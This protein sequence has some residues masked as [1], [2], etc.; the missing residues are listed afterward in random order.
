MNDFFARQD[1]ARRKSGYLVFHFAGALL[2]IVVLM[3]LIILVIFGSETKRL[4]VPELFLGVTAVTSAILGFGS[5]YKTL[6][7]R[8]GGASVASMMGGELIQTNTTDPLLRRVLNLVEEMAI[9]SGVPMPPVFL[10]PHEKGINAFAAGY[11]P[12]DAV[13]GV[14]RGAV[15]TLTRDELQG[16]I[17]H[18][19]SHILNGDMRLNIRLI[20]WVHGILLIHI[21]GYWVFRG[22]LEVSQSRDGAKIGIPL[23]A[24]GVAFMALGLI[25]VLFGRMI[26]SAV[27]RQREYLADAS[28]VQFT[29]NPDGIGNALVKIGRLSDHSRIKHR[30]AE[31]IS[32]MFFGSPFKRMS[33]LMS[34]HPPLVNRIQRILPHFDGNFPQITAQEI[35]DVRQSALVGGGP[36]PSMLSHTSGPPSVTVDG[37]EV[38]AEPSEMLEVVGAPFREHLEASRRLISRLPDELLQAARE[39]FGS[40]A[41]VYVLLLDDNPDIRERQLDVLRKQADQPVYDETL[42]LLKWEH[43]LTAE[44]RL[45]LVDLSLGALRIV[46]GSVRGFS[47]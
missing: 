26:K 19:F 32:H 23:M 6:A 11:N 7:L 17:A 45:P 42:R 37:K 27:S 4:F 12:D 38:V 31:E 8:Q 21:V 43:E 34:T 2:A 35:S 47:R 16:V 20:G 13:V 15:E 18:E 46:S 44:M 24:A 1:E 36:V 40:R 41:L 9:A 10:M 14:T 29:R 28:A 25:G 3:Y 5:L 39:P 22:S 30:R 33:G